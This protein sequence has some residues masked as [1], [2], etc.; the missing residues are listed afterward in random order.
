MRH[1]HPIFE[2]CPKMKNSYAQTWAEK[3]FVAGRAGKPLDALEDEGDTTWNP[4]AR[5]A[6]IRGWESAG[7][8]IHTR[9]I[10][11]Q[12]ERWEKERT[13]LLDRLAWLDEKLTQN[14]LEN[15]HED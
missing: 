13:E 7:G 9:V 10:V 4:G 3:G 15:P 5:L 11:T 1:M 6:W 2:K 8:D 12:R 14:G